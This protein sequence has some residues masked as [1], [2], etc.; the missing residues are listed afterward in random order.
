MRMKKVIIAAIAIFLVGM[1]VLGKDITVQ[2]ENSI[3]IATE[4]V[5][6]VVKPGEKNTITIPIKSLKSYLA[7]VSIS[8]E[9]EDDT[10]FTISRPQLYYYDNVTTGITADATTAVKFDVIVDDTAKIGYY[11]ITLKFT[12]QAYSYSADKEG[13]T[14]ITTPL[15]INLRITEEKSPAQLTISKVSSKDAVLGNDTELSFYIKNEGEI[16]AHNIYIKLNYGENG[17]VNRYT[18]EKIKIGDLMP[19]QEYAV[20]LPIRILPTANTGVV[21]IPVDFTYKTAAG[22]ELT[23]TYNISIEVAEGDIAPKLD[24][25]SVTYNGELWPGDDFIL[26]ATIRNYG[27][28]MANDVAVSVDPSSIGADKFIKNYFTDVIE[29]RNIRKDDSVDVKIPLIVSKDITGGINELKLN[30]SYTNELGM[31]LTSSKTIYLEILTQ[32]NIII[33]A[34]TQ[35]PAKPMAGESLEVS[36]DME[37]KSQYDIKDVK[38]YLNNLSDTT[39]IPRNPKPYIYLEELKGGTKERITIPLMVSDQINEGLNHLEIRYTYEGKPEG[40]AIKIPILDVQ[41]EAENSSSMP[42]LIVSQYSTDVEQIKAGSTFNFTFDLHN[43]HSSAVAK[44]ITVTITQNENVFAPTQGGNSFFINK[45]T[46]GQSVQ[47]TIELKVK[48][49]ASTGTYPIDIKINYEFDGA[50]TNPETGEIGVTKTEKL[51]LQVVENYRPVVDYVSVYSWD[52][53]LQVNNPAT[54]SF[55]FYNMGKSTLNNVV[56][57]VSGDFVKADGSMFL[58]G[59]VTAGSSSYEEFEVIPLVEGIAKGV[60]TITFEDSNGDELSITEEFEQ[61]VMGELKWEDDF[62]IDYDDV[63]APQVPEPKKPIL[64]VWLFAIIEVVFFL[65]ACVITRKV[66]ISIYKVKLR[67]KE[68]EQF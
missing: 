49:D 13:F 62:D 22:T 38:I 44:N 27:G 12:Y 23:D 63:F 46:P 33:D 4:N 50:A 15:N 34:V 25:D 18:A 5:D 58:V 66:I 42:K 41:N 36:F 19:N 53:D 26:I 17:I 55:E 59:N 3:V 20:T 52:G 47:N 57:T 56:A 8:L 60:L 16:K 28:S 43:T 2:A 65:I 40:E 9:T 21:T 54:L 29:V 7:D 30:I 24:I 61:F 1:G 14:T 31:T 32:P 51:N 45:I 64:P 68:E 6:L 37:N 39:F 11:P 67:K 48:A 35:K 10:P